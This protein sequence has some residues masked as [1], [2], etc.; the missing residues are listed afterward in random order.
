M[1]TNKRKREDLRR[2]ANAVGQTKLSF[3]KQK[4]SV[5]GTEEVSL[6]D[7]FILNLSNFHSQNYCT[8]FDGFVSSSYL[9]KN[10]SFNREAFIFEDSLRWEHKFPPWKYIFRGIFN[11]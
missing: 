11:F 5:S 9:L 3:K 10:M 4:S 8:F 1:P 7:F 2:S 6:I